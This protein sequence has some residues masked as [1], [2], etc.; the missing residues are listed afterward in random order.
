MP[1]GLPDHHRPHGVPHR[2]PPRDPGCHTRDQ[3]RRY[4]WRSAIAVGPKSSSGHTHP[5]RGFHVGPVAV[6]TGGGERKTGI[7]PSPADVWPLRIGKTVARVT[8]CSSPVASQGSGRCP[9]LRA[10]H[11]GGSGS[12]RGALAGSFQPPVP[13]HVRRS[14]AP[15]PS[16][17]PPRAGRGAV[18]KHRSG[19]DRDLFRGRPGQRRLLH[20]QLPAY[21][22]PAT[23]G[24]PSQLP[25]RGAPYS[26][27]GVRRSCLRPPPE[28]HVSRSRAGFPP[29]ALLAANHKRRSDD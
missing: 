23:T 17:P 7:R 26:C 16:D 24:L 11:G 29:V 14:A 10:H 21:V 18:A 6:R 4:Q 9:V 27:S 15:I 12:Y 22:R 20:H 8:A 25:A 2:A 3:S 1:R 28:P 13:A 19:R 5:G